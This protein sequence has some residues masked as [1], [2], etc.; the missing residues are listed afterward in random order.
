VENDTIG[1]GH[2]RARLEE[3]EEWYR[4]KRGNRRGQNR[5]RLGTAQ[6]R[7]RRWGGRTEQ[8]QDRTGLDMGDKIEQEMNRT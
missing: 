4:P 3:Q 6:N 8:E 1:T 5:T 2:N 7:T